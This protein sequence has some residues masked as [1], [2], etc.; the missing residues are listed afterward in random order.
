MTI[1]RTRI[2]IYTVVSA[3]LGGVVLL[4]IP[5][6]ATAPRSNTQENA[7]LNNLRQL[8]GAAEQWRVENNRK[9]NEFPTL[10][11]A[12]IYIKGGVPICPANGAYKFDVAKGLPTCSIHAHILP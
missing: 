11:Q 9:T 1:S 8:D 12:S 5:R 10:V 6:F 2:A 7:C 3:I 4:T